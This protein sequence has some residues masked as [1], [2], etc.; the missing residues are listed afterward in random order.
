MT[1]VSLLVWKIEPWA[2]RRCADF[3]RIHQ[4]AVVGQRDHALVRLH[5]DGLGIEQ[6]RVASGGVA[7]V[8]DG[9]RAVELR[10]NILGEDVGHQSHGAMGAQSQPVGGDDAR[11][12][13][14]AML[15]RMQ[16]EVSQLLRLRVSV[17]G[18]HAAFV[19]K[20]VEHS[21]PLAL[22]FQPPRST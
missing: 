18:H 21:Q 8:P 13:L 16:P 15:Q 20:F 11:R 17:D 19:M 5:H 7:R 14:S 1:S 12:F 6:S 9:E 10:Q 3:L 4:V 2:S 22:S